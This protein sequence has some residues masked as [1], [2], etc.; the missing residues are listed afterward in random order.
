VLR[1]QPT[2]GEFVTLSPNVGPSGP[3]AWC[4]D[5]QGNLYF[6]STSDGLWRMDA[7]CG[8]SPYS[9]G[10]EKL[11]AELL[12]CNPKISDTY[13][14]V[15]YDPRFRCLWI[16]IDKSGSGDDEFWSYDLQA[17]N[18]A[19]FRHTFD[20]GPLRLGTLLK[21]AA[22]EDKSALLALDNSGTIYQYDQASSESFDAYSWNGPIAPGGQGRE[23]MFHALQATFAEGSDNVTW[24][25]YVGDSPEAAYAGGVGTPKASGSFTRDGLSTWRHCMSRAAFGYLKLLTPDSGNRWS[26]ENVN[27]KVSALGL[28]RATAT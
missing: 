4:H 19:F 24:E 27:A 9:I 16:Y 8:D 6:M 26:Q 15:S 11:P 18:G 22:T 12:N 5:G 25:L 17:P 3:A 28:R 7:G 14:S 13:V 1:G 21:G 2:T 10:R 20:N 23:G